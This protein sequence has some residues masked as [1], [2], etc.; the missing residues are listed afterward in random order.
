LVWVIF[1]I[2]FSKYPA[3]GKAPDKFEIHVTTHID[4]SI[5]GSP[6]VNFDLA[7]VFNEDAVF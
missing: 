2:V 5:G 1:V 3:N 4:A 7:G 6:I